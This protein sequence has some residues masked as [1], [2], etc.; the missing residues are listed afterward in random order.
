MIGTGSQIQ[1]YG[2]TLMLTGGLSIG[3]AATNA[4]LYLEPC[5]KTQTY[6]HH[7]RRIANKPRHATTTSRPVSMIFSYY[8]PNPVIDVH[9]RW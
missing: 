6:L 2:R 5:T 4:W 9:R 8:N 3:T 7:G 1:P